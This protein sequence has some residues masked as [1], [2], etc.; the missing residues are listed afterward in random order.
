[1]EKGIFVAHHVSKYNNLE[2]STVC[3]N[4]GIKQEIKLLKVCYTAVIVRWFKDTDILARPAS[5]N[6]F[7]W[8]HS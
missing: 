3:M 2:G 5:V 6:T 8:L 4:S 7:T 1:M